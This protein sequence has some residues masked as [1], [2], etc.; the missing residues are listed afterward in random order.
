MNEES[1]PN[2]TRLREFRGEVD[3]SV[4]ARDQADA[5]RAIDEAIEDML[6]RN[7]IEASVAVV[8]ERGREHWAI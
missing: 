2:W 1:T 7:V 5:E 8:R 3:V 6:D 4:F